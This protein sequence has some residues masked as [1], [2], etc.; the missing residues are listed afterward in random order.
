[1]CFLLE[2]SFS[3]HVQRKNHS[4]ENVFVSLLAESSLKGN[5]LLSRDANISF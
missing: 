2:V 1:M 4:G 3:A 5:N